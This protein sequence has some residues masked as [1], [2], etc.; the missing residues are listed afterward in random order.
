MSIFSPW[1][2]AMTART[3]EPMGPMHA[4][5]APSPGTR[6]RTATLV[7]CPASR[8]MAVIS[9]EPSATSGTSSSKSLR[10]RFGCVRLNVI[11]APFIPRATSST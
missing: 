6:E 1:S 11:C 3:R 5:L 2:S 7:R 8:A 9:T 10:T 4:P